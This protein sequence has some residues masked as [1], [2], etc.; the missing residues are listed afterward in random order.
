MNKK[1]KRF[2]WNF[3][4]ESDLIE[5]I[6]NDRRKL[7]DEIVS[8]EVHGHVGAILLLRELARSKG[9]IT[10]AILCKIQTFITAEQHEKKSGKRLPVR[11]M[12]QY[13]NTR[14]SIVSRELVVSFAKKRPKFSTITKVIKKC[15][16]P[17]E[18]PVLM[19]QWF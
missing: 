17:S 6:E 12:G 2:L 8:G 5:G 15:L 13:R 10:E 14:A 1:E 3:V 4:Y 7:R 9:F 18:I 11:F 19:K 16:L